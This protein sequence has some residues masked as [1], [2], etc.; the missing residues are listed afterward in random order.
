MTAILIDKALLS[1]S[2]TRSNHK[3]YYV[4]SSI[5]KKDLLYLLLIHDPIT[6]NLTFLSVYQFNMFVLI[7]SLILTATYPNIVSALLPFVFFTVKQ[8]AYFPALLYLCTGFLAV[9]VVPS[10]K[11]H[12]H[13]VCD[14]VLLSVY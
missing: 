3:S 12:F 2:I 10:P 5:G 14:P 6:L 8:T 9:E 13:E 11:L 7:C 4:I 1:K